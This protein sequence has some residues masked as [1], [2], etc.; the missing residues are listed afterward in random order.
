MHPNVFFVILMHF[1]KT[2]AQSISVH[3]YHWS[4]LTGLVLS[5]VILPDVFTEGKSITEHNRN[6]SWDDTLGRD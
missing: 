5:E 3:L 4:I 2:T 6:D 1:Y